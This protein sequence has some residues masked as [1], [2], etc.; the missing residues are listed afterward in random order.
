M[1]FNK[2][3]IRKLAGMNDKSK[4]LTRGKGLFEKFLARKR[5]DMATRL[6]SKTHK[7]SILDVGCGYYPYF[8]TKVSFQKKYGVDP[9]LATVDAKNIKLKKLDVSKNAMPFSNNYFDA[10]TMLA[11]FEHIEGGRLE[12]VLKEAHRV[13][14]KR[15]VF[16]ITTPAPWADRLLHV[17]AMFGLI[18]SKEIHEHKHNHSKKRIEDFLKSAGFDGANIKSGFF[19]MGLNMWFA[20]K[21]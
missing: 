5:A 9:S 15:G 13:L 20:A 21:K 8:L 2:V 18:S 10:V 4:N 6:L 7:G 1:V 3:S 16:I 11:V 17:M 14:R 19:E 12:F